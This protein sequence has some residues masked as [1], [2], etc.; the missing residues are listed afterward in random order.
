MRRS[1]QVRR[2]FTLVEL[3]VIIGIIA[4]LIAI[5]MPALAKAREQANAV[6]CMSNERQRG[7]PVVIFTNDH[8]CYLPKAWFNDGVLWSNMNNGQTTWEYREPMYGWTYL[9]SLYLGKNKGLFRVPPPPTDHM[10]D[11]ENG[12]GA[13]GEDPTDDDI[14]GSYRPNLSDLPT[15]PYTRL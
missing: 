3:L 4:L 7:Q 10:Y 14:P 6:K 2:G 1:S 8:R 9:L 5:L 15:A 13:G 11:T 12:P